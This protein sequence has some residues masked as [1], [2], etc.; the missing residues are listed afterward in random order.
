MLAGLSV[1]RSYG[2]EGSRV[3]HYIRAYGSRLSKVALR[4]EVCTGMVA[5]LKCAC[6]NPE[7][8]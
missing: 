4:G 3:K 7:H 8:N 2:I 1:S 5:F 6:D